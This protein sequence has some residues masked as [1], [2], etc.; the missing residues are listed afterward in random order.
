[1]VVTFIFM[2]QEIYLFEENTSL[3]TKSNVLHGQSRGT[4]CLLAFTESFASLVIRVVLFAGYAAR[5]LY[6]LPS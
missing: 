6:I 4:A 3:E 5:I 1:M 2:K